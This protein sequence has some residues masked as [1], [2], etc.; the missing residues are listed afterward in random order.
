M[1][2]KHTDLIDRYT[3][4]IFWSDEDEEFVAVCKEFPSLSVLH[5]SDVR[6]FIGIKETVRDVLSNMRNDE[7]PPEPII[8][9]H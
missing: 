1:S 3:Y 2:S 7:K 4:E 9:R 8:D 5:E 6:A